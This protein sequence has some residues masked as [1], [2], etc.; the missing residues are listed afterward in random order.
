MPYVGSPTYWRFSS[1]AEQQCIQNF[2]NK[3]KQGRKPADSIDLV[4]LTGEKLIA[5]MI[6]FLEIIIIVHHVVIILAVTGT[7]LVNTEQSL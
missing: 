4:S 1:R 2:Q 5:I 7:S 6:L 3:N